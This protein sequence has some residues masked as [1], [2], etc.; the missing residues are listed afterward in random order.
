VLSTSYR[1]GLSSRAA[2]LGIDPGTLDEAGRSI[3]GAVQAASTLPTESGRRLFDAATDAFGPAIHACML[4]ALLICVAG[5]VVGLVWLP[6]NREIG[7]SALQLPTNP[8][9]P[10]LDPE[11]ERS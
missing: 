4:V 10:L 9:E 11:G 8:V 2:G 7:P 1:G 3:A 6:N 5:I